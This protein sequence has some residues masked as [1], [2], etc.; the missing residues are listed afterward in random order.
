MDELLIIFLSSPLLSSS[1]PFACRLA[2]WLPGCSST[3]PPVRL[4][5]YSSAH[6]PAWPAWPVRLHIYPSAHIPAC[7]AWLPARSFLPRAPIY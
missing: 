1:P 7:P 6:I 3:G 5:I 2:F 4:H